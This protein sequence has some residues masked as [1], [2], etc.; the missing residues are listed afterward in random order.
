M[1]P[2][3]IAV[4]GDPIVVLFRR[5]HSTRNPF[6]VLT[7]RGRIFFMTVPHV[8]YC[9]TVVCTLR[10]PCNFFIHVSSHFTYFIISLHQQVSLLRSQP[11]VSDMLVSA[12]TWLRQSGS[13]LWYC[14]IGS[15]E[16][17]KQF[18]I[19]IFLFSISN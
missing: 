16:F 5:L 9:L 18:S 14:F 7:S 3:L 4:D 15:S 6:Q 13:I 19:T 11:I 10:G 17:K 2:S 12:L 1:N 8:I